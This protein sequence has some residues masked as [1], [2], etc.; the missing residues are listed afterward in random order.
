MSS[1]CRRRGRRQTVSR[2]CALVEI[3]VWQSKPDD[4]KFFTHEWETDVASRWQSAPMRHQ[5]G[6]T[7]PDRRGQI[8]KDAGV[9]S[10]G[11]LQHD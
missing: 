1:T 10:R 6:E 4:E 3:Y 2:T 11:C 8:K 5:D 9:P 7:T